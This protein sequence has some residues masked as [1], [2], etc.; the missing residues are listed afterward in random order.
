MKL[1]A[2]TLA[3]PDASFEEICKTYPK[4]G[5]EAIEIRGIK[6]QL[7]LTKVPEFNDENLSKSL[8]ML[9]ENKLEVTCLSVSASFA[10]KKPDELEKSLTEAKDHI[11]LANK[12]NASFIRV[13]GGSIP[14]EMS[15]EEAIKIVAENLRGLGDFAKPYN[16]KVLLETH[17][18][19][20]FSKNVAEVIK[21]TNN[22]PNVGVCWDMSNSFHA[23]AS[24]EDSVNL[25]SKFIDYVH[26]KDGKDVN[27]L[28]LCGEGKIPVEKA[29]KMLKSI[30]YEKY[31]CVEWEKMWHPEITDASIALPQ[32]AKKLNEYYGG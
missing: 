4:Y 16:I 19:F 24:I 22:H 26:I 31:F 8:K 18:H 13:F 15:L 20:S 2:S 11:I 23:G 1:A 30:K 6:K 14:K 10:G 25:L 17:D 27:T 12:M 32:Y 3:T 29:I 5:Y 9:K 21:Q 28:A 7:Y